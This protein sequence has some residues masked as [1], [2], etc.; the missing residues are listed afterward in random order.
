MKEG[1]D[2]LYVFHDADDHG[3]QFHYEG[4]KTLAEH[5]V[6]ALSEIVRHDPTVL[7]V[8]D[9]PPGWKASR[10]KRGD[11]WLRAVNPSEEEGDPAG[12][13]NDRAAPGRV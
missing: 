5:M 9:L 1:R 12:T 11:A 6:V 8:A 2:I 3:W 13:D 7:E 4:E 10:K